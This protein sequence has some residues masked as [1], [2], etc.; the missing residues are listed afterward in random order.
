MLE[1]KI[2]KDDPN[3]IATHLCEKMDK[4]RTRALDTEEMKILLSLLLTTKSKDETIIDAMFKDITAKSWALKAVYERQ[5]H[6]FGNELVD[7]ATLIMLDV[8]SKDNIGT[9]LMYLYYIQWKAFENNWDK[10][11]ITSFCEE[12]FPW[13]VVSEENLH[14][15]WDATKVRGERTT[16]NLIDYTYCTKSFN[17][18]I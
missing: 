18:N 11:N 1:E 8:V 6:V 10:V 3:A 16:N 12:L 17:K 15:L 14:K 2:I 4:L 9:M 5:K 13:G 7:K